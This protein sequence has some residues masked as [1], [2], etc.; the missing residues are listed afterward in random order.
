[1]VHNFVVGFLIIIK[2][3]INFIAHLEDC[4]IEAK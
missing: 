4:G 3:T 1:M 2:L